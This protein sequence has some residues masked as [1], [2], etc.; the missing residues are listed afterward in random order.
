MTICVIVREVS[1]GLLA[2]HGWYNQLAL[3]TEAE[4]R[5]FVSRVETSGEWVYVA[6]NVLPE[7][8]VA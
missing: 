4:A 6:H 3:P 5:E 2:E 7:G 8:G 1:T